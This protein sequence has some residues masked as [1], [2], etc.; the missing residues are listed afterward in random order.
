M[1]RILAASFLSVVAA[2]ILACCSSSP[3]PRT[4]NGQTSLNDET[5]AALSQFSNKDSGLQ[6]FLN[7]AY[8][9]VVFPNVKEGAVGVGGAYGKGEV[10]QG[11]Q[12]IGY[13]DL[14]QANIG[15]QLGGQSFAEVVAFQNA[16]SFDQFRNGQLSFDTRASAVAAAHGAAAA[17]DYQKGVAVFTNTESGL[18]VQAAIGGQKFRYDSTSG[19]A[20]V[21]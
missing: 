8:A 6:N 17:A 10:F 12:M 1:K 4:A 21:R 18:M 11:N 13:A 2:A 3:V 20:N 16:G 9:Y 14:S 7:N 19:T 15:V 5:Q